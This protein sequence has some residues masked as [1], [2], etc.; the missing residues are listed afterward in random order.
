MVID[1]L[2]QVL[3]EHV[4]SRDLRRCRAEKV[5]PGL[6]YQIVCVLRVGRACQRCE[7]PLALVERLRT[8]RGRACRAVNC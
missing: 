1:A 4:T 8:G 5:V 3:D 6:L 2:H 7:D